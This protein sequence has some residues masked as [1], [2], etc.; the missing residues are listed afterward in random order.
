MTRRYLM[1][2][3][4]YFAVDYAINPWMDPS[5]PVDVDLANAQWSTLAR[6][7]RRLGHTVELIEPIPGLPD[8]VF[9]ANGATVIDGSVLGSQFRYPERTEEGPAYLNWFARN[10]FVT[11]EAKSTNEGEGDLLLTER[12]L[13]AG[14]G[15]RTDLDAHSQAQELFGRPVI[16][17]QL[18]DPRFYHLDTALTVL[19]GPAGVAYLP[20]AFSAGS[21]K[22][23]RQLFP[24][25]VIAAE[26]DAAV[27]GLNAVSDGHHVV[28]PVQARG[29]AAHLR[30]RGYEPVG[31]DLCELRKAGAV[32]EAEHWT[33][34]NYHPL[35][36]V[37]ADAEGAWVTDVDGRRYLD[38]L[39][40]YSALNFGHRHPALVGAARDQLD[41]L[42][43][44]SRAFLHDQFGPFCRELAQLCETDLTLPMNTGPEARND[45][46]PYT[47]GFRI[48][49]YGDLE[50]MAEAIDDTTVA[51]LI[52]PIQGEAGVLVPPPGYLAGLRALCTARNVL[53]VCDEIQSGLGRTGETFAC[54]HEGVVPDLYLL[55]KAL[56]GGVVPVS[57]VVGRR[58]VLGVFRPGEH[59]STFG[60]NPLACAVGRAVIA[61]LRTGEY[62]ERARTLGAVLHERL[63]G[64]VGRGVT[65]VRGRGLWAGVD[66]DP[67]LM[68]GREASQR[69]M[70][71]GVLAKDTHG[72]TIRLAPP[73]VI[74]EDEVHW[75]VDRLAAVVSGAVASPR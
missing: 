61:L 46:G 73:L 33:A 25:A 16:T 63:A 64:L 37:I 49:P 28:M 68:T 3:P 2:P 74:T 70:A 10:G 32:A 53:L 75:A 7:Y 56:G 67:A 21:Q 15:F 58:D 50:A 38:C 8:M 45:F 40:G 27:L 11:Q 48:V 18:V 57:A 69:L 24:D 14:T 44:T 54:R 34:R 66:I 55:G 47:P 29:L 9:A 51:V 4:T 22:V 39:A 60:G 17:L 5:T 12:F 71:L 65:A 20:E 43:L 35:P 72:S 1:C 30:N 59:G 62:Q 41:R 36:V 19:G 52:E 23:L 13:L 31:V 42:T 6:T 26:E